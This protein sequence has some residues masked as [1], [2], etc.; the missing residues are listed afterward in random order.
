MVVRAASG[1][2]GGV[3]MKHLSLVTLTFQ[4]SALILVRL[5]FM[6]DDD[7]RASKKRTHD[8]NC[9]YEGPERVSG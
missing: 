9:V 8:A 1:T 7:P 2:L 5:P 6:A 3:S 4:N